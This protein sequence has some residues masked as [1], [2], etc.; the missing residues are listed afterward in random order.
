MAQFE[1]SSNRSLAKMILKRSG[2][3]PR[4][5]MK[6]QLFVEM[7]EEVSLMSRGLRAVDLDRS[8]CVSRSIKNFDNRVVSSQTSVQ[9]GLKDHQS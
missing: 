7:N 5:I 4:G 9:N 2:R 3:I 8:C 1:V 6:P